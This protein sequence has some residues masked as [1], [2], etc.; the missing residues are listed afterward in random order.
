MKY[1]IEIDVGLG[2]IIS[3]AIICLVLF[4]IVAGF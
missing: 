1:E 4:W 2:V 3:V